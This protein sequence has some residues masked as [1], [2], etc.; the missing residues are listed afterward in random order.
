YKDST[1]APVTIEMRDNA[2]G[3]ALKLTVIGVLDQ[4][5]LN[6][7]TLGVGIYTG[8]NSFAA[9]GIPVAPPN[10]YVFRV[11]PGANVH[12]TAL[13]LGKTFLRNGLDV[14][15]SQKEFDTQQAVGIGLFDL[16]EGFMGLGL[17]VGIAALGVIATRAVVE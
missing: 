5:A 6:L 3:K 1:V 8:A 15:E 17:I 4:R 2:S 12:T 11:A 14:K 9:A 16:L 13:A 7:D 10:F